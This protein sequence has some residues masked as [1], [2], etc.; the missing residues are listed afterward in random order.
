MDRLNERINTIKNVKSLKDPTRYE[1]NIQ[2]RHTIILDDLSKGMDKLYNNENLQGSFNRFK[3]YY[4]DNLSSMDENTI[5]LFNYVKDDYIERYETN[6]EFIVDR[7]RLDM[8]NKEIMQM[9]D[10]YGNAFNKENFTAEELGANTG[11]G[12]PVRDEYMTDYEFETKQKYFDDN[13]E[14]AQGIYYTNVAKQLKEYTVKFKEFESQFGAKYSDRI[15]GYNAPFGNLKDTFK[16]QTEMLGFLWR[17]A[18]SEGAIDIKEYQALQHYMDTGEDDLMVEYDDYFKRFTIDTQKD[19]Q[20]KMGFLDEQLTGMQNALDQYEITKSDPNA[21]AGIYINPETQDEYNLQHVY[22]GAN[23]GDVN[24]QTKARAQELKNKVSEYRTY[25]DKLNSSYYSVSG[26]NYLQD[27]GNT[28][29]AINDFYNNFT[30]LGTDIIT[31]ERGEARG[32]YGEGKD[33]TIPSN[34]FGDYSGD[35]TDAMIDKVLNNEEELK[36]QKIIDNKNLFDAARNNGEKHYTDVDGNKKTTQKSDEDDVQWANALKQ[37]SNQSEYH[38]QFNPNEFE[39]PLAEMVVENHLADD[40]PDSKPIFEEVFD[41]MDV[42]LYDNNTIKKD[43]A[44]KTIGHQDIELS[45]KDPGQYGIILTDKEK[46]D[47]LKEWFRNIFVHTHQAVIGR[48]QTKAFNSF[49]QTFQSYIA[50]RAQFGS[51]HQ[52]TK[53]VYKR[54]EHAYNKMS[55]GSKGSQETLTQKSQREYKEKQIS[56]LK[57]KIDKLEE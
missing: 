56:L 33:F 23:I 27:L 26:V 39:L 24:D 18:E 6:N 9:V 11:F 42:A 10:N 14:K 7:N 19:A 32:K 8:Q 4:N 25:I 51:H 13:L 52:K 15:N 31:G 34:E 46:E 30:G 55:I 21:S 5:E 28:N 54:L 48:P 35:S 37:F 3:E 1:A 50:Y 57:D 40:K 45:L 53:Q 20:I 41:A 17:S 43:I 44:N 47:E 22:K 38:Y 29:S 49:W 2:N 16:N 36:N 12:R